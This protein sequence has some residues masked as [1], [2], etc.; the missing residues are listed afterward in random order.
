MDYEQFFVELKNHFLQKNLKFS[1]D[2]EDAVEEIKLNSIYVV[3][4]AQRHRNDPEVKHFTDALCCT[5]RIFF[6]SYYAQDMEELLSFLS[7][8]LL[9]ETEFVPD[10][11]HNR[12]L[13]SC[14]KNPWSKNYWNLWL[15]LNHEN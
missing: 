6:N 5:E 15:K 9:R 2:Y 11:I 12:M 14:W 13:L 4:A 7:F 8:Y 10:E 1:W 3:A